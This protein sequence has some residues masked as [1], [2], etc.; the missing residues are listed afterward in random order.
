MGEKLQLLTPPP[1]FLCSFRQPALSETKGWSEAR[2]FQELRA[3]GRLQG[4]QGR[5]GWARL[6]PYLASVRAAE[7]MSTYRWGSAQISS[8]KWSL[9]MAVHWTGRGAVQTHPF[10]HPPLLLCQI[11]LMFSSLT[12]LFSERV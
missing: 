6:A 5:H 1:D 8:G 4:R 3:T 10:L 12:S 11:L 7:P 2:A 9:A